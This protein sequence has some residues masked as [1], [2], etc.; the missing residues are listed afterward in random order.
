MSAESYDQYDEEFPI[1][2]TKSMFE[3]TSDVGA[4][5][6]PP[7]SKP[8]NDDP[9][10]LTRAYQSFCSMQTFVKSNMPK[11]AAENAFTDS[12]SLEAEAVL[13]ELRNGLGFVEEFKAFLNDVVSIEESY[14]ASIESALAQSLDRSNIRSA[15]RCSQVSDCFTKVLSDFQVG[16]DAR[17]GILE[18]LRNLESNT[19]QFHAESLQSLAS[20]EL[21]DKMFTE[22]FAE[23]KVTMEVSR[24]KCQ[25]LVD[26]IVKKSM[27]S[28]TKRAW[29]KAYSRCLDY[30]QSII[31]AN[32]FLF[33]YMLIQMPLELNRM[34]RL[35]ESRLNFFG[36]AM[37]ELGQC[38]LALAEVQSTLGTGFD[39]EAQRL[40]VAK[41]IHNLVDKLTERSKLEASLNECESDATLATYAAPFVYDLPLT[42]AN[43]RAMVDRNK[44]RPIDLSGTVTSIIESQSLVWPELSHLQLPRIFTCLKR[45]IED[46]GGCACEG[47]FRVGGSFNEAQGLYE[48]LQS[49]DYQIYITTAYTAA[50]L[51][52]RWMRE[53]SE[54]L[55]T[56]AFVEEVIE[57]TKRIDL[58]PDDLEL[59]YQ[60]V[61]VYKRLPEGNQLV[62]QGILRIM[63]D[64]SSVENIA[65][66][67]MTLEN[68]AIIFSPSFLWRSST[69][70]RSSELVLLS[71]LGTRLILV[72]ANLVDTSGYPRKEEGATRS[73]NVVPNKVNPKHSQKIM[74]FHK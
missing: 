62:I 7:S 15:S 23:L 46:L 17:K 16:I 21:D 18:R 41:E 56:H 32:Q 6:E 72:L 73:V 9:P 10:A 45:A 8:A 33:S 36:E 43:L 25:K 14:H 13:G 31:S 59:Q 37:D 68:L 66:T 63:H 70:K 30:E 48:Q 74:G 69:S 26:P 44:D 35:E 5:L 2:E 12:L 11:L 40:D 38:Y 20:L 49:G 65:A 71:K 3:C 34:Q 28:N 64:I 29:R 27:F 51:L 58:D 60:L 42:V 24:K 22:T 47:I 4:K 67:K 19:S 57:I 54:P 1:D 39:R 52:K 61:G 50:A 53:M 55:M